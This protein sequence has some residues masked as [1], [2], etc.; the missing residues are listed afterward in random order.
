[1]MP[2]LLT[3]LIGPHIAKETYFEWILGNGWWL[4]ILFLI[5]ISRWTHPEM[6]KK[7]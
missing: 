3:A 4:A 6:W 2:F 5:G 7:E 1:M